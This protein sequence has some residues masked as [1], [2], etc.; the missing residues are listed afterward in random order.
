MTL[1]LAD[2]RR[3]D[4]INDDERLK[5]PQTAKILPASAPGVSCDDTCASHHMHCQPK[6][7][8]FADTCDA[9]TA[10]FKCT[11]GCGHQLGIELPAFVTQASEATVGQCLI[12]NGGAVPTCQSK[13]RATQRLCVCG[14]L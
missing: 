14:A 5:L 12:A 10:N 11:N 4:Y 6:L 8:P 9:L 3:N 2:S 13:H 1:Y 7:L